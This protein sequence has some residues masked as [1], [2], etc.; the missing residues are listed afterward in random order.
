MNTFFHETRVKSTSS[1]LRQ[2]R[3]PPNK[4]IV[5]DE[6]MAKKKAARK[7][8]LRDP[9]LFASDAEVWHNASLDRV[10]MPWE[11]YA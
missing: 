9:P 1:V 4:G 8:E 6:A 11:L 2:R 7:T 5:G 10:H 3:N